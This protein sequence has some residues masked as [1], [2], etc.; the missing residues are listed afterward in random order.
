MWSHLSVLQRILRFRDFEKRM[1]NLHFGFGL[2]WYALLR[3]FVIQNG[4]EAGEIP[5]VSYLTETGVN[6][7]FKTAI[8]T[9]LLTFFL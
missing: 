1:K 2:V 6:F 3:L 9:F 5:F 4:E 8:E 7:Q